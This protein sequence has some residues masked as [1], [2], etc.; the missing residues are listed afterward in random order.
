MVQ[1]ILII[2]SG[3]LYTKL[4][5]KHVYANKLNMLGIEDILKIGYEYTYPKTTPSTL[6]NFP[7]IIL[8]LS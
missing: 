2:H 5:L 6:Y 3:G 4:Y 1:N 8:D 7:Y